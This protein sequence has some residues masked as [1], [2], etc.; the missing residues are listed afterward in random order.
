[1]IHSWRPRGS[2]WD[3]S[4]WS[5]TRRHSSDAL[6]GCDTRERSVVTAA[7]D[8][9]ALHSDTFYTGSDGWIDAYNYQSTIGAACLGEAFESLVVFASCT[10]CSES[11]DLIHFVFHSNRLQSSDPIHCC[12]TCR[13]MMTTKSGSVAEL[14]L[15]CF[16][17]ESVEVEAEW[18]DVWLDRVYNTPCRRLRSVGDDSYF[19]TLGSYD[20]DSA[21]ASW[22][23][24]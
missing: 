10:F 6:L 14:A 12:C 5:D 2:S 9:S 16:H 17:V 3:Q 8:G 21:G 24:N 20:M 23:R 22:C 15:R 1:M 13:P 7:A 4:W 11:C 19:A 18:L